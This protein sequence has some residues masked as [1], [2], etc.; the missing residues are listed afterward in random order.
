MCFFK[1]ESMGCQKS[2]GILCKYNAARKKQVL[3]F[4]QLP[5]EAS[6]EHEKEKVRE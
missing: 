5:E 6:K 1:A 4:N 3:F 2:Q